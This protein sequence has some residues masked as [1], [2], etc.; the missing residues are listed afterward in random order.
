MSIITLYARQEPALDRQLRRME[1]GVKRYDTCIYTDPEC[2]RLKVRW[3]WY[4]HPPRSR[5]RVILNCCTWALR[6]LPKIQQI[7]P[8]SILPSAGYED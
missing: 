8:F 3:S 6:W 5:K 1:P 4:K 7:G 2:R